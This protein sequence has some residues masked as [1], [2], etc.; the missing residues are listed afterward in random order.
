M[1]LWII[2]IGIFDLFSC[3]DFVVLLVLGGISVK[4]EDYEDEIVFGENVVV[5]VVLVKK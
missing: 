2:I 3:G 5:M 1:L 4:C